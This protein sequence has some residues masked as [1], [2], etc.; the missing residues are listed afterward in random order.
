MCTTTAS[1]GEEQ[2]R[3]AAA[4]SVTRHLVDQPE[5]SHPDLP[6]TRPEQPAAQEPESPNCRTA[7]ELMEEIVDLRRRLETQ[8]VIEQA[9]G[10]LIGGYGVDAEVAFS[11]LVRCSQN[12]NVRLNVLAA[13]LVAAANQPGA[14]PSTAVRLFLGGLSA[15]DSDASEHRQQ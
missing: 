11:V 1:T 7:A 3:P 15:G 8:P 10:V 2:G 12:T 9:K 6:G 14:E 5:P 4:G 13:R